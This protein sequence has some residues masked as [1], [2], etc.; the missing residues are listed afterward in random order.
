MVQAVVENLYRLEDHPSAIIKA[1]KCA[2][3]RIGLCQSV[4]AE[5][6]QPFGA[7][8]QRLIGERLEKLQQLLGLGPEH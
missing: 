6:F 2:L 1:L 7:E 5:P 4:L 3:A 8:K